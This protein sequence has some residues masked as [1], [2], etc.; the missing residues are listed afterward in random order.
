[1]A[2]LSAPP[3]LSEDEH[4]QALLQ[5]QVALFEY[6]LAAEPEQDA[7]QTQALNQ[8]FARISGLRSPV[9]GLWLVIDARQQVR[10]AN[11]QAGRLLGIQ[12]RALPGRPLAE[13]L[14]D[15]AELLLQ[16]ATHPDGAINVETRFRHYDGEWVPVLLSMAQEQ[17]SDGQIQYVLVGIDLRERREMELQL[18]QAQKLEAMG[19]LAA[20]MAH[21]INTPLQFLSDNLGFIDDSCGDLLTV[22]SLA[23]REAVP[24]GALSQALARLDVDFVQAHLPQALR[25]SHDGV[26][27]VRDIVNSLRSF[28][29]PGEVAVP[30]DLAQLVHQAVTMTAHDL[31]QVAE[32]KLA[33]EPVPPV[34]CR[35]DLILQVLINLLTNAAHAIAERQRQRPGQGHVT[36][37]LY[38]H[39]GGQQARLSVSDDGCGI[40]DAIR[41]R[42]FDPFFTTK[43]VGQGTGQGLAISRSLIVEQHGGELWWEPVAAGGTTFVIALPL[44]GEIS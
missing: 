7:Q 37:S 2:D 32:V 27:R 35:R 19:S 9:P 31:R 5:Q 20:G 39:E 4:A 28:A 41:H 16:V 43:A 25:R 15:A 38:L 8:A 33:L 3:V 6:A 14:P 44:S 13:L 22:L 17:N 21:E 10:H 40:D 36:L 12:C 11:E 29:H 24:N 18:R 30:E 42:V 1:M 34:S 26:R 23:C